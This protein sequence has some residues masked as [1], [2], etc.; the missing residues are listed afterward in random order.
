VVVNLAATR[1]YDGT[2][3]FTAGSFSFTMTGTVNGETL[4]IASGT[5]TVASRTC[6]RI[7]RRST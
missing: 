3:N 1:V 6:R 2:V 4:T 5:G 7:P